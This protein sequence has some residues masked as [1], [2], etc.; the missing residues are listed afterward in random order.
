VASTDVPPDEHAMAELSVREAFEAMARFLTE[1]HERAGDDLVTL[2]ADIGIESDGG[3]LDPAAWDDGLRCVKAVKDA[4]GPV[5][6]LT[7]ARE[8]VLD[9]LARVTAAQIADT[10]YEHGVY[11]MA[12]TFAWG[13]GTWW[14]WV[15][16]PILMLNTK[17]EYLAKTGDRR[18]VAYWDPWDPAPENYA[19]P[20]EIDIGPLGA[21]RPVEAR[22]TDSPRFERLA[23]RLQDEWL[24]ARAEL[25]RDEDPLGFQQRFALDLAIRLNRVAWQGRLRVTNDFCVYPW[26]RDEPDLELVRQAVPSAIAERLSRSGWL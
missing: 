4:R 15:P 16:L 8:A 26:A 14:C 3:T 18:P 11:A 21:Y 6:G 24:D 19:E 17:L 2:L 7:R 5:T 12:I 13:R 10:G 20:W 23:E 25:E 1:Y 22:L 9:E